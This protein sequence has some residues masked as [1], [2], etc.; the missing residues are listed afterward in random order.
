LPRKYVHEIYANEI[1]LLAYYIAAVNIENAYHDMMR[2]TEYEPFEGIVLTD[3]FQAWE[4][5][6]DQTKLILLDENAGVWA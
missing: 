3:T 4:E 1:V 5:N 2:L 6:T